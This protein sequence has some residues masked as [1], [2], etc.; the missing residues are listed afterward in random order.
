[1]TGKIEMAA[2]SVTYREIRFVIGNEL[3]QCYVLCEA[4]GDA[5]LGVQGWHHKTFP[6][7]ISVAEILQGMFG[8][9]GCILWP[10]N[11]PDPYQP[12]KA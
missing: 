10:L 1:M 2:A 9:D 3:T 4:G 7:S 8:P 12:T 11:A 5:P 6:P